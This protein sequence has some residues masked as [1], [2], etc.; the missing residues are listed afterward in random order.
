MTGM[1]PGG[2]VY[3]K[4]QK[5]S[6][7]KLQRAAL[8]PFWTALA[9]R[10]SSPVDILCIGDSLTEGAYVST[11]EKR[12]VA[13][14]RDKLRAAYPTAGV[15]GGQGFISANYHTI[16][17]GN[18]GVEVNQVMTQTGGSTDAGY[19]LGLGRRYRKFT[20]TGNV[21]ATVTC[22]SVDAIYTQGTSR[23]TLGLSIDGGAAATIATAGGLLATKKFNSG[24]LTPGSHTVTVSWQSGGEVD[25]EGIMVY[26]G[27]E[28]KGIRLWES[29]HGGVETDFFNG[30]FWQTG[31][32]NIAPALVTI[33]LG[34]NDLMFNTGANYPSN[35]VPGRIQ[36]L[37]ASI[38][39]QCDTAAIA[40]PT[41]LLV[42]PHQ[43][44]GS[45]LE[46][47]ANYVNALWTVALA[48][49]AIAILDLTELVGI[50]TT[51]SGLFATDLIHLND[52][53]GEFWANAIMGAIAP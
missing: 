21:S 13:R 10:E 6:D 1:I 2:T 14:L 45:Y 38:R 34:V 47:W 33:C 29:G 32:R 23:G 24:A 18:P 39:A 22:S 26:N 12:W 49:P 19:T 30:G 8:R 20:T 35:L 3:T 41:F 52:V 9:K 16:G 48:D 5:L 28:T 37:I 15:T 51:A 40:Y 43:V 17:P 4:H 36:T 27:D 53:G 25:V 50:A 11:I 46:P 44:A 7:R 31:I 42:I